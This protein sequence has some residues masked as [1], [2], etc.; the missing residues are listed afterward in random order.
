MDERTAAQI[1]TLLTQAAEALNKSDT[2]T[3][4]TLAETLLD[5]EELPDAAWVSALTVRAKAL[6]NDG[7]L[8]DSL[9]DLDAVLQ[10]VPDDAEALVTRGYVQRCMGMYAEAAADYRA[11]V[12]A[13][14]DGPH[15]EAAAGLLEVLEEGPDD[16]PAPWEVGVGRPLVVYE[17]SWG[18]IALADCWEP[19]PEPLDPPASRWTTGDIDLDLIIGGA[20]PTGDATFDELFDELIA[21]SSR[22][23]GEV[24][25]ENAIVHTREQLGGLPA[26]MI[27]A[28]STVPR[29]VLASL[30]LQGPAQVL[31][32]RMIDHRPGVEAVQCMN[33][34][35]TLLDGVRLPA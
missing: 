33:H 24:F 11:A 26:H 10:L 7:L 5:D 15:G 14:P 2:A 16:T 32:A 35:M 1:V 30:I 27:T 20:V 19:H 6:L 8:P 29:L 9:E 18:A 3:A 22:T 4:I 34:L 17:E 31:N 13:D 12:E 25:D 28:V 23:L 21:S